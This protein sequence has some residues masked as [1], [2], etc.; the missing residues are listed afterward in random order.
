M[1][2]QGFAVSPRTSAAAIINTFERWRS[3]APLSRHL[4]CRVLSGVLDPL[5]THPN[6]MR[7]A[8]LMLNHFSHKLCEFEWRLADE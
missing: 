6:I 2:T 7:L 8:S 4:L 1:P 3:P 5:P